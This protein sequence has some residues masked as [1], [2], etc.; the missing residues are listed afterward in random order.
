MGNMWI[1]AAH[2]YLTFSIYVRNIFVQSNNMNKIVYYS[3]HISERRK[4]SNPPTHQANQ[5]TFVF[6]ILLLWWFVLPYMSMYFFCVCYNISNII[7]IQEKQRGQDII[8][9]KKNIFF[10][11]VRCIH[12]EYCVFGIFVYISQK[13]EFG[14]FTYSHSKHYT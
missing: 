6:P 2:T 13:C 8:L 1:L 11:Y 14:V 9:Y 4:N 10:F 5:P 7:I 3:K 12:G